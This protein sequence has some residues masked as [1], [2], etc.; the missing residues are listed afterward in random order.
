MD[1]AKDELKGPGAVFSGL[2]PGNKSRYPPS[3]SSGSVGDH[4]C[5]TTK[6]VASQNKNL[7][8]R[9]IWVSLIYVASEPR[10]LSRSNVLTYPVEDE[11]HCITTRDNLQ[12]ALNGITAEQFGSSGWTPG[13]DPSDSR[14]QWTSESLLRCA[15]ST[16]AIDSF[17]F[18]RAVKPGSR[19]NF[20]AVKKHAEGVLVRV[21]SHKYL[22]LFTYRP[23]DFYKLASKLTIFLWRTGIGHANRAPPRLGSLVVLVDFARAVDRGILF[24]QNSTTTMHLAICL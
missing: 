24:C 1:P 18:G 16:I 14:F 4:K 6:S 15:R 21:T 2:R 23:P 3:C 5:E 19:G 17:K 8:R 7:K 9:L 13:C 12:E 22:D 10:Q 20:I 11:E